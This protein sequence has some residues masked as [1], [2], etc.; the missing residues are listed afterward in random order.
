M[1]KLVNNKEIIKIIKIDIYYFLDNLKLEN[2][3]NHFIYINV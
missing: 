3:I 2:K 1:N